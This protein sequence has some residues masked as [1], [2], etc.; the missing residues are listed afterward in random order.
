MKVEKLVLTSG[1]SNPIQDISLP[2]TFPTGHPRR[3]DIVER[4]C[5]S[6]T[7]LHDEIEHDFAIANALS[8]YDRFRMLDILF[9]VDESLKCLSVDDIIDG[10]RLVRKL[11]C[12]DLVLD[13]DNLAFAKGTEVS[14]EDGDEE[15]N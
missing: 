7:C 13:G 3:D 2:T 5:G 4:N 8:S 6:E 14:V 10:L 15:H 11:S 12:I 9:R 1:T